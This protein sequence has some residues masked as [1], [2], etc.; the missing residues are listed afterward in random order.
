MESCAASLPQSAFVDW[1]SRWGTWL[2]QAFSQDEDEG[3][4]CQAADLADQE[5]RLR[6]LERGRAQRFSPLPRGL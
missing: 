1:K 3:W 2:R 4:L 6:H 5:R